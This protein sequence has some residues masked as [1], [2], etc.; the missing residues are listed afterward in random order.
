MSF[1]EIALKFKSRKYTKFDEIS[2]E[3][4]K[5]RKKNKKTKFGSCLPCFLP[6]ELC[7]G[8]AC[9]GG[10]YNVLLCFE[11]IEDQIF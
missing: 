8:T 10:F 1:K 2:T 7:L 6:C 5:M 9:V 3:D 11:D 4:I